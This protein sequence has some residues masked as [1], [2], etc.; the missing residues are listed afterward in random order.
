ML[1]EN[2]TLETGTVVT[3]KIVGGDEVI[4]RFQSLTPEE[5]TV[6]KPLVVMMGQQGFGLVPFI[7]SADPDAKV[8]IK[9]STVIST[10]KTY[11]PVAAEYTKQTSSIK[12]PG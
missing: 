10:V 5:I 8:A 9:N 12:I 3:I 2:N 1:I 11:K 6:T 7:L 4:G